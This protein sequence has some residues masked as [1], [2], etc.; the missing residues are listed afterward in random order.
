MVS[1]RWLAR[2]LLLV[3]FAVVMLACTDDADPAFRGPPPT[4]EAVSDSIVRVT[5][6]GCGTPALGSGFAV[7]EH[8]LVT[9]AH[10]VTGRDPD[11]LSVIRPNGDEAGGVLVAFDPDLDL[12]I[13]RVD[14]L[15]FRPVELI[16]GES[17][18]RGAAMVVRSGNDVDEVDFVVD[19]RVNVNWDGVYR[20]TTSRFRGL[21]LDAEIN[22]GDSGGGLFVSGTEVIG[23]VHSTTRSNDPRGYAVSATEISDLVATI[24]ETAEVTAPRCA[25]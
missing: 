22:R 2:L 17:G 7:S 9:S 1:R 20:D 12:A 10:L 24:D 25:P 19:A 8:L 23:L 14:D 21:R 18:N 13:L 11:S 3:A 16:E 15:S 5:G 4:V 6:L